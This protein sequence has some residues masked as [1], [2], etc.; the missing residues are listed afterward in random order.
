VIL[1]A[2]GCRYLAN[3]YAIDPSLREQ[4]QSHFLELPGSRGALGF[5][6]SGKLKSDHE[7]IFLIAKSVRQVHY[8][9][10][11]IDGQTVENSEDA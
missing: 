5:I 1:L 3:G 9:I 7:C 6:I 2:S 4:L 8:P 10:D 11:L